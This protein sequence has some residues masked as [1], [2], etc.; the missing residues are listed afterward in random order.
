MSIER[1]SPTTLRQPRRAQTARMLQQTRRLALFVADLNRHPGQS[2]VDRMNSILALEKPPETVNTDHEVLTKLLMGVTIGFSSLVLVF[3]EERFKKNKTLKK[4]FATALGKE[5]KVR[6]QQSRPALRLTK[7]KRHRFTHGFHRFT[8]GP[9]AESENGAILRHMRNCFAHG[10]W[11][12]SDSDANTGQLGIKLIDYD[13]AQ[14][15]NDKCTFQAEVDLMFLLEITERLLL[16][17][18]KY[19]AR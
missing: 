10:N 19:L 5:L 17:A 8:T 11:Q 3:L 13:P 15:G 6:M 12:V 7:L 14:P 4:R 9:R 16:I 1:K 18:F 2:T